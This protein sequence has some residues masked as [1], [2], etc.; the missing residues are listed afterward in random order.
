MA[1]WREDI[2]FRFKHTGRRLVLEV[3]LIKALSFAAFHVGL[4]YKYIESSS[5]S[6]SETKNQLEGR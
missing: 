2:V 4:H 6:V 1:G 5:R 3:L